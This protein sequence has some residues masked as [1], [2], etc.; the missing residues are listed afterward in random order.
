MII[1]YVYNSSEVPQSPNQARVE[2]VGEHSAHI[3][4][5]QPE[6]DSAGIST[7]FKGNHTLLLKCKFPVHSFLFL[8]CNSNLERLNTVG[9]AFNDSQNAVN[10]AGLLT[11]SFFF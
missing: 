1:Y 5:L 11:Q 10:F 8:I 3:W 6:T 7:K 9:F 4:W 2:V